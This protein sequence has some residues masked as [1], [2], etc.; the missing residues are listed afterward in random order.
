MDLK[1]LLFIA[2]SACCLLLTPYSLLLTLLPSQF[3]QD[4]LVLLV[5]SGLFEEIRPPFRVLL[6]DSVLRHRRIFS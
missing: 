2:V 6:K 4:G 3:G 5:Q 1:G